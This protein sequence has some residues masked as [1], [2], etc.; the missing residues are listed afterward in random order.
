MC[1]SLLKII[2]TTWLFA[3][4]CCRFGSSH[5]SECMHVY[6]TQASHSKRYYVILRAWVCFP[7]SHFIPFSSSLAPSVRFSHSYFDSFSPPSHS[8]SLHHV[9]S[10]ASLS[11][12]AVLLLP[13]TA[14]FCSSI[15][16]RLDYHHRYRYV[17]TYSTDLQS[18]QLL[19]W[20]A[21]FKYKHT[22]D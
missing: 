10:F 9:F 12:L 6:E 22:I 21:V 11:H 19:Y 13:I 3:I 20:Q 15:P 1:S 2:K 8:S 16:G 4:S 14:V 7:T 17:K 18:T 5:A